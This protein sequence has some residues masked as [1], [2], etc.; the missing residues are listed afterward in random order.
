MNCSGTRHWFHIANSCHCLPPLQLGY[1]CRHR[2]GNAILRWL[3]VPARH[4]EANTGR[5][6]RGPGCTS[7]P[8][9]GCSA[10][11]KAAF[12]PPHLWGAK[13]KNETQSHL[14]DVF[15]CLAA[16]GLSRK[17]S[18]NSFGEGQVSLSATD[19]KRLV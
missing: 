8:I 9:L 5:R 7:W 2:G 13:P 10:P 3:I 15:K 17:G 6:W 12:C 18:R 19:K 1:C 11:Y 14:R 16:Q 4:R